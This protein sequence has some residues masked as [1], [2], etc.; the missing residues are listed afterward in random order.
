MKICKHFIKNE[1]IIGIGPV[2]RT[3]SGQYAFTLHLRGYSFQMES[4]SHPQGF[5][6][7]YDS[8]KEKILVLLG[9]KEDE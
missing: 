2:S 8:A 6:S 9:D 7:S 1:E 5:L 4:E 3:A